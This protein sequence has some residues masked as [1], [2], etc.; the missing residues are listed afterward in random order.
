MT[1]GRRCVIEFCGHAGRTGVGNSS[2][3]GGE[4]EEAACRYQESGYGTENLGKGQAVKRV[5]GVHVR[6][7][8]GLG[9][10]SHPRRI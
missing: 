1:I 9:A 6:Q 4:R 5:Q 10:E 3:K 2:G 7:S 8:A